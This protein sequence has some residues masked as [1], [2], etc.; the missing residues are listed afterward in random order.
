MT[1]SWIIR[2]GVT[3]GNYRLRL[4]LAYKPGLDFRDIR[5]QTKRKEQGW[6]A[7]DVLYLAGRK[8]SITV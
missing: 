6:F 8:S 7:S 5:G 3:R 4:N 2:L 1:S